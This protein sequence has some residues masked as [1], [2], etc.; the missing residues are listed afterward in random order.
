MSTLNTAYSDVDDSCCAKVIKAIDSVNSNVNVL[1]PTGT[2]EALNSP[3][4]KGTWS[5]DLDPNKDRP[6]SG[7]FRR[8]YTKDIKPVCNQDTDADPVCDLPTFLA[9]DPKDNY[10][11]ADHYI[12][13]SVK[14]EITLDVE[15]F[16]R[17]CLS[18]EQYI[19][20]RLLA[21]RAG[22]HEE[23][24]KK[25]IDRVIGYVGQYHSQLG[26]G[27]NSINAAQSVSFLT[28][29]TNG[30]FLFD[31][32]GYSTIKDQYAQLGY[33]YMTPLIVGGSH[34]SIFQTNA[35]FMG[36]TNLNGVNST[37]VPNLYT[38]YGID[39]AMADGLD[40]LAT[41]KPGALQIAEV[42][43]ITDAMIRLSVLNS[44]ERM[45]IPDPFGTGLGLWDFL[46]DVDPS[47]CQYK[48]KFQKWFDVILPVPASECAPKPVLF[49]N[50]D[51]AGNPCPESGYPSGLGGLG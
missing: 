13:L 32:T 35:G 14:R 22:V 40:W 16:T 26:T 30:G 3:A 51:C 10:V 4:N 5:L 18:P 9:D 11:F 49:F 50:V 36:G 31:P 39:V 25:A 42:N 34:L 8:V 23:V 38:D 12:D 37:G 15:E 7:S 27:S 19:A 29:G 43:E 45:R 41:W 46:Y 28:T 2:W 20:D 24:N 21:F 44:R 17:F 1:R 33:P 48:L 6:T 47:G